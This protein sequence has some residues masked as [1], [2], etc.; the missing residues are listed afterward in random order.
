MSWNHR[1]LAH[2][3]KDDV[4]LKIHEVYYDLN[5]IPNGYTA[6]PI[7]I[8]SDDLK[9]MFWTI[10]QIQN[11]LKKPVLWAGEDFPN[12]CKVKYTCD[13]C[14]RDTFDKPSPHQCKDGLRKRKLSW[15]VRYQ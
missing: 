11:S 6:N 3:H 12:E 5:G 8:E 15:S 1:V 7:T 10:K 13:I 9:G 2:K 4:Y 14:G